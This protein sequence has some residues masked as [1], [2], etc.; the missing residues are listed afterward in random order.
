MSAY[1]KT[2]QSI[3]PSSISE[4]LNRDAERVC[5]HILPSGK[6]VG[7]EWLVGDYGG[8]EGKS[9]RIVLQGEKVGIS[10]D[11]STGESKG[12]LLD[13]WCEVR[14]ISLREAIIEACSFLGIRADGESSRP[15][16][17]YRKPERPKLVKRLAEGG[18]VKN[19]LK[20]RKLTDETLE[21]YRVAE[22]GNEWMVFPYLR[23]GEL[24]NTKYISIHRDDGKKRVRQQSGAEPCL[25][26]WD[27]IEKKHAIKR[28]V[29]LTEGEIDCMTLNQ[30][31]IP[32]LSIP[33]GGGGGKKQDW[34]ENDY[35]RLMA[36]DVI[37]LCLDDDEVGKA[38]EEEIIS[39][40]GSERCRV[41][42]LPM[43]DANE[44][45]MHGI[46]NFA[47][48]FN[49]AL[50][51][52]PDELKSADYFTD[53]VMD[54]FYPASGTYLGMRTPW[55]G[56]NINLMFRRP[57]LILWFGYSGCGKSVILNQVALQGMMDG[58]KF[59]IASMEMPPH[60]TLW[61]LVKQ[62][63]GLA[64]PSKAQVNA[65]MQWL[66]DKLWLFNLV[67]TAKC[68]RLFEV[69][70]YARC[71]YGIKNFVIDSLT[72]MDI[73]EDDY[74]GQKS[75]AVSCVDFTHRHDA[76]I[77]LVAHSRKG[78][79]ESAIPGKFDI[80]GATGVSDV[81]STVISV[82]RWKEQKQKAVFEKPKFKN[83][84][85]EEPQSHYDTVLSVSKQRENGWEGKIG[86]YF[87]SDTQ[88]FQDQ[89]IVSAIDYYNMIGLTH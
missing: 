67:G 1:L 29:A 76:T 38:A 45:L 57:E 41:V 49:K 78:E 37:Y 47:A 14:N 15:K 34:V 44:C 56:A 24:I 22:E 72:K 3:T 8:G 86:L 7:N 21:L 87:D 52:D 26:G 89:E 53:R 60:V 36:F 79:D 75:F 33:N 70:R 39:R 42:R 23:E 66:S 25:F 82:W 63:T 19:Y 64:E 84:E 2:S 71:R 5:R 85:A 74:S 88:Q 69:F 31:G 81:A 59:C 4:L 32:A 62:I 65:V 30:C 40:L 16:R 43:K 80:R 55:K 50:S 17:S 12:D 13:V 51:L 6:R 9:C 27:V 58:E 10:C 68:D 20:S 48:Y 83:R 73:R 35:D 18:D 28:K 46:V 54:R 61:R 77:H 11:F